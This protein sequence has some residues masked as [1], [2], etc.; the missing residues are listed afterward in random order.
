MIDQVL[1]FVIPAAYDLLPPA[2]ASD[3][4]TAMLLA[5]G[6][7]ESEFKHRKQ[8]GGGPARGFWQFEKGTRDTLGG[9]TGICQHPKTR[10]LLADALRRMRYGHIIG[11]AVEIHYVIEDNDPIACVCAR[12]LLWTL[13][14][15]LP[16]PGEPDEAFRQYI[17]AWRPGAWKNGT[18]T[19]RARLRAKF[20]ANFTDAWQRVRLSQ[21]EIP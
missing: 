20:D 17:D 18:A 12:L 14:A 13:P 19:E 15:R 16:L 5:T 7:Q 9:V 3:S 4:A 21:Q 10:D 11:K 8:G 1:R 6:N 2:M